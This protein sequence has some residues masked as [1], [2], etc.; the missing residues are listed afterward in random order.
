MYIP[1]HTGAVSCQNTAV[2][3]VQD[4]PRLVHLC[5]LAL[6]LAWQ[7]ICLQDY[8]VFNLIVVI[9]NVM[10]MSTQYKVVCVQRF[11]GLQF[12]PCVN[13]WRFDKVLVNVWP[14]KG[15]QFSWVLNPLTWIECK[16][17]GQRD[18]I[19]Y[20]KSNYLNRHSKKKERKKSKRSGLWV[21]SPF[22]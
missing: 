16:R 11:V 3:L 19:F 20:Q 14:L 21:S 10:Y 17:V 7:D 22:N 12:I 1:S 9:I 18:A 6:S 13:G 4:N 5:F 2:I 8:K 15:W